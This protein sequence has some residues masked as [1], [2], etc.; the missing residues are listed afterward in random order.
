MKCYEM[1][2]QWNRV[3]ETIIELLRN[4]VW[5]ASNAQ[6]TLF[7]VY[8]LKRVVSLT[9]RCSSPLST[10]LPH[11]APP[12]GKPFGANKKRNPHRLHLREA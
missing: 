6:L 9:Q 8:E 10:L 3:S 1:T 12:V 11:K 2:P 5:E 7:G 4:F